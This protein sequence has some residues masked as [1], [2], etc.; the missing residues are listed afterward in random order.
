MEMAK[1]VLLFSRI[2]SVFAHQEKTETVT[3]ISPYAWFE[4]TVRDPVTGQVV[5]EEGYSRGYSVDAGKDLIIRSP[6]KYLIEF[7][8]NELSAEIQVSVPKEG[9]PA[10]S[11][12]RTMSCKF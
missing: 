10:G 2:R 6:G 11:P 3:T 4:V 5:A 9:N 1:N 8:G 7:S 12:V